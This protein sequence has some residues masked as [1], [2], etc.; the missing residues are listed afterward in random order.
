MRPTTTLAPPAGD[1]QAMYR[2]TPAPLTH[3]A[4]AG[5]EES[6]WFTL[7]HDMKNLLAGVENVLKLATLK[8]EGIETRVRRLLL[9]AQLNC[10][11]MGEMLG[12]VLDLYALR[13]DGPS[14]VVA[15]VNLILVVE[16]CVRLLKFMAEEKNI[17]LRVALPERPP[18]LLLDEQRFTRVL[19]NLLHNAMKFSAPGK[20]VDLDVCVEGRE[21]VVITVTDYGKGID[22]QRARGLSSAEYRPRD[23]ARGGQTQG[24]GIGLQ[25]CRAAM[26]SMG[27]ELWVESPPSG[28]ETGSRFGLR[29]PLLRGDEL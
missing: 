3:E 1:V 23:A 5:Q 2:L 27:G 14:A 22:R 16:K 11:A 8:P 7:A 17:T 20:R 21:S 6:A 13:R 24:Y 28:A 12:D 26:P 4:D 9:D 19:L 18:K 15:E 25:Y 10:E 29:L